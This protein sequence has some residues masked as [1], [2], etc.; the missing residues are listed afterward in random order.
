MKPHYV[1]RFP[2]SFNNGEGGGWKMDG[3]TPV[4][5][6][7]NPVWVCLLYTSDAADE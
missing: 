4:F 5:K 7:G 3:D 2:R 6:D 1:L